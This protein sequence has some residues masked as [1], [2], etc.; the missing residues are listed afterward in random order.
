M[1]AGAVPVAAADARGELDKLRLLGWN[2][3][4]FSTAEIAIAVISG[5]EQE[6]ES[7]LRNSQN[8]GVQAYGRMRASPLF[9]RL[10]KLP[11]LTQAE[12]AMAAEFKAAQ[13]RAAELKLAKLGL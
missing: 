7:L 13:K 3:A 10:W 9:D 8:R 6:A 4:S 11:P 12:P 2:D 1:N 5:N